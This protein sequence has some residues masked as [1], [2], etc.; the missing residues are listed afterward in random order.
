MH[1]KIRPLTNSFLPPPALP[2]PSH[3]HFALSYTSC[4]IYMYCKNFLLQTIKNAK[5]SYTLE[6][7]YCL[8]CD[9]TGPAIFPALVVSS[10]FNMAR[11]SLYCLRGTIVLSTFRYDSRSTVAHWNVRFRCGFRFYASY[12]CTSTPFFIFLKIRF[13][14][15]GTRFPRTKFWAFLAVFVRRSFSTLEC[16]FSTRDPAF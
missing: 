12:A 13:Q 14:W 15:P 1:K 7:S 3:K 5:I 9:T 8:V 6:I 11:Q 2:H 4:F 10:V 16:P